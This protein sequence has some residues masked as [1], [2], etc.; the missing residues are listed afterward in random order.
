MSTMNSDGGI[1]PR[2]SPPREE[3]DIVTITQHRRSRQPANVP[4][5]RGDPLAEFEQ[6]QDQM[7]Q[8]I[9]AFFGGPQSGGAGQQPIWIPASDLEETD[10]AYIIELELPGVRRDDVSIELRD[11]EVR[12]SGEVKQRERTGTLRRQTRRVGQFE[13]TVMLPGDI[14]A[15][16]VDAALHDGLLTVRLPKAAANPPRQ[17]EIKED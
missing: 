3:I 7:G 5:R 12:I 4:A 11:N 10:D 13:Y 2:P 16:N 17:I 1:A 14:D 15:E 9:N 6:L 8:I